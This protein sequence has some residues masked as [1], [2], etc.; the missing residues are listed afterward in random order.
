MSALLEFVAPAYAV[1]KLGIS[2]NPLAKTSV[3]K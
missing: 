3:F 1:W 2:G